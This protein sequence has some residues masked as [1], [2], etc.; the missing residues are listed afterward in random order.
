MHLTDA[1]LRFLRGPRRR[2][3]PW[4][5]FV[6]YTDTHSPF[7]GSPQRFVDAYRQCTFADIPDEPFALCHGQ[8]KPN[9]FEQSPETF[10]QSRKYRA[11]Y[12]AAVSMIDQQM[13][14]IIDE[15][16]NRG[17]VEDTLI[18]YTSD[19]GHMNGH[20]GLWCKGNATTPQ[21][22]LDESIRVPCLLSWPGGFKQG[23][24]RDAPVDHCDLH[25]TFLDV[26]RYEGDDEL[27]VNP[28]RTY[29]PLLR[30]EIDQSG[31]RDAQCCEYANARMI[32]TRSMKLIR[33]YDGPN[34]HFRDELYDL[35]A[36][37]RETQNVIDDPRR[38]SQVEQ[39]AQ[40]LDGYFTH[41]TEP[42]RSGLR[43]AELPRLNDDEPWYRKLSG[44]ARAQ[45][46]ADEVV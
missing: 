11:Q 28:G 31:W 29:L 8:A 20:H 41:Y 32:R 34:G 18:V 5:C 10:E 46:I 25:A 26:A 2:D 22:F 44:G 12:Y 43:I 23:Q 21:N 17:E 9:A 40:R 27:K 30:G 45:L 7:S 15:L 42:S 19:H 35:E 33:R 6:G 4:F 37:P 38:A 36:D 13:G 1:A 3:E 39:F 14:R 16:D 24:V